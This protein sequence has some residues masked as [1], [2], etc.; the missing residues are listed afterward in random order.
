MHDV[1]VWD[2]LGLEK[3]QDSDLEPMLHADD[4]DTTATEGE[5]NVKDH[6]KHDC[7]EGTSSQEATSCE[8]SDSEVTSR[9][10]LLLV[11]LSK[12]MKLSMNPCR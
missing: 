12:V 5:D 8:S 7:S 9:L 2:E 1:P 10:L 4:C 3:Q 11:R 6:S